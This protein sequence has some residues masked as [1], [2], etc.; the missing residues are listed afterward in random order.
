MKQIAFRGR[1]FLQKILIALSIGAVA[2]TFQACHEETQVLVIGTVKSA[3][4]K[5]PIPGIKVSTYNY[6]CFTDSNGDFDLYIIDYGQII[7]FED[8]D[9]IEYGEF[10][11][12]EF[13]TDKKDVTP[14]YVLMDRKN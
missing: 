1:L 4:T 14:I 12:K 13:A 7:V 5:M 8:I 10:N 3:D 2:F 6:Y 9:G 11:E